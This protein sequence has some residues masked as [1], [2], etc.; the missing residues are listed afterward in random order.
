[1]RAGTAESA[2][3]P[4]RH[5]VAGPLA[6]RGR[7]RWLA[8]DCDR[9]ILQPRPRAQDIAD[10]YIDHY[11]GPDCFGLAR[12]GTL[13]DAGQIREELLRWSAASCS[14]VL[15]FPS[16]GGLGQAGLLAEARHAAG[17]ASGTP[18]TDDLIKKGPRRWNSGSAW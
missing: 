9:A 13:T 10:R 11:P 8:T 1:M 14:D 12:T 15:L 4:G 16:A 18:S 3:V 17:P 7:A 6:G 5:D 2:A